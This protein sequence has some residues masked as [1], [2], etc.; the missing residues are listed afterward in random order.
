MRCLVGGE[1]QAPPTERPATGGVERSG[2]GATNAADL[3][4]GYKK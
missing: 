4:R 2:F 1:I 3:H